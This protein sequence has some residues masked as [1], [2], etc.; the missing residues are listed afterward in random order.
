MPIYEFTCKSCNEQFEVL[1]RNNEQP[2]C[3][4]CGTDQLER[5]L[6]TIAAHSA[7][8]QLP[9]CE[10][11]FPGTCGRPECGMGGCQMS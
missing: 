1:V 11:S 2:S 10:P 4:R 3:P 6:S 8:N 9:V 7:G 5:L